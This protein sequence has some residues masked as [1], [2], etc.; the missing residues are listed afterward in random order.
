MGRA[1][2]IRP[3]IDEYRTPVRAAAPQAVALARALGALFGRGING[4]AGTVRYGYPAIGD[5]AKYAGYAIPPQ[6]FTGFDP[7]KVAAGA[8]RGTPGALPSTS[9]PT[10]LLNN[11][12]Q[13]SMAT[14]TDQQLAGQ[15]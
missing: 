13:R 4:Q 12:L 15:S 3:G 2:I 8:F 6:L 7:R 5:R 14:V 10:T 1:R 9:S 11:P